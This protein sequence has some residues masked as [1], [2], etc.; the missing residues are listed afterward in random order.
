M[1]HVNNH[2]DIL[3][4]PWLFFD[5]PFPTAAFCNHSGSGQFF[6]N[7]ATTGSLYRRR[8]AEAAARTSRPRPAA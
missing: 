4:S 5:E 6:L 8:P 7:I 2:I 3:I 1:H